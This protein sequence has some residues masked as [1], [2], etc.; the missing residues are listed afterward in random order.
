MKSKMWLSLFVIGGLVCM[1]ARAQGPLN[2]TSGPT[3]SM[4]TL[5]QIE[6]RLAITNASI[7]GLALMLD[8]PGGS[9]YLTRDIQQL[10]PGNPVIWIVAPDVT[11]DLNGFEVIGESSDFYSYGIRVDAPNA[12]IRN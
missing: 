6:P 10:A 5:T 8:T 9:Y 4:K 12:A 11:L 1:S 7:H 2:P 3:E